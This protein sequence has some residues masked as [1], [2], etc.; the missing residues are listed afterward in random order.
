MIYW[1][2]SLRQICRKFTRSFL[3]VLALIIGTVMVVAV[4]T[5]VSITKQLVEKDTKLF[6]QQ[7]GIEILSTKGEFSEKI[8]KKIHNIKGV[9]H[10]LATLTQDAS[11]LNASPDKDSDINQNNVDSI[12]LYAWNNLKDSKL[13]LIPSTGSLSRK[14]LIVDKITADLWNVKKDDFVTLKINGSIH[15]VKVTAIV[16]ENN[17]L[18]GPS[19]WTDARI[20]QWKAALPLTQLQEWSGQDGQVE[21]IDVDLDPKLKEMAIGKIKT[22]LNNYKDIYFKRIVRNNPVGLGSLFQGLD[23]LAILG[24][25]SGGLIFYGTFHVNVEERKK[26]FAIYKALGY[27]PSQVAGLLL[28]EAVIIVVPSLII[29]TVLG[30]QSSYL[31]SVALKQVLH[32]NSNLDSTN[33]IAVSLAVVSMVLVC[34]ISIA[35]PIRT[36]IKASVIDALRNLSIEIRTKKFD[37]PLIG[38]LIAVLCIIAG[39]AL[40]TKEIGILFLIIGT[41]LFMPFWFDGALKGCVSILSKFF[42]IEGMVAARNIE[43]RSKRMM[44]SASLLTICVAFSFIGSYA[45]IG[46]QNSIQQHGKMLNGG[47]VTFTFNKPVTNEVLDQITHIKGVRNA[48]L[49]QTKNGYWENKGEW[50]ELPII[51]I[52]KNAEQQLFTSNDPYKKVLN[53]LGEKNTIA[54]SSAT[55][56]EW[57]GHIGESI[58]L[59]TPKGIRAYKVVASVSAVGNGAYMSDTSFQ[60]AFGT[61]KTNRLSLLTNNKTS[62]EDVKAKIINRFGNSI[63]DMT[64]AHSLT[65]SLQHKLSAPFLMIRVLLLLAVLI[66]GIGLWIQ[67]EIKVLERKNELNLMKAIGLTTRQ[68]T[69][70]LLLE[71]MTSGTIGTVAGTMIGLLLSWWLVA[72]GGVS[73]GIGIPFFFPIMIIV[74]TALFGII[75]SIMASLIPAYKTRFIKINDSY[76]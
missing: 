33:W 11:I 24:L 59:Q 48:Y 25:L 49:F 70:S 15:K 3:T 17:Y 19:S 73:V 23:L 29:G 37:Y 1:V 76:L 16:K 64:S 51:K 47:D 63:T 69:V 28:R 31:L 53:E 36:A 34:V 40:F 26:E 12:K 75:V 14:G 54:L 71:G 41:F 72:S 68:L 7:S 42:G 44:L 2:I 8:D 50:N 57:E 45:Y 9:K 32:I 55:L 60:N 67:Q 22:E 58:D 35:I 43:K 56:K 66:A 65:T 4:F 62:E 74:T 38:K 10:S 61:L 5:S 30:I 13:D 46:L 21:L 52:P 20:N 18:D 6:N 39:M 27:I